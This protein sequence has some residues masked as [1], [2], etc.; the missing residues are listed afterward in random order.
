VPDNRDPILDVKNAL[1]VATDINNIVEGRGKSSSRFRIQL[2]DG[3]RQEGYRTQGSEVE[4]T[5]IEIAPWEEALI[6]RY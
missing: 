6:E 5:N 2:R 1:S 3:S 4:S